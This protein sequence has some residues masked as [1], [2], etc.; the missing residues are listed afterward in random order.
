MNKDKITTITELPK[1]IE[2][3]YECRLL[4]SSIPT[5]QEDGTIK[6]ICKEGCDK[7]AMAR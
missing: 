4:H 2:K 6:Y 7:D 5:R 1:K 3:H